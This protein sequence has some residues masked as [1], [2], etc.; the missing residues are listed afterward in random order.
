GAR[1]CLLGTGSSPGSTARLAARPTL[2]TTRSAAAQRRPAARRRGRPNPA[3]ARGHGLQ[4]AHC[5]APAQGACVS[6]VCAAASPRQRSTAA[7][8]PARRARRATPARAPRPCAPWHTIHIYTR[9]CDTRLRLLRALSV[10]P[11]VKG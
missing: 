4:R 9:L 10:P 2:P 6:H 7:A 5:G 8:A 11:T 1:S 3:P